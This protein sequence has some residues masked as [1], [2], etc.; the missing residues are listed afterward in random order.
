M[1]NLEKGKRL[2]NKGFGWERY[3]KGKVGGF[4]KVLAHFNMEIGV[5]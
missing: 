5:I 2:I 4:L 1:L 3:F